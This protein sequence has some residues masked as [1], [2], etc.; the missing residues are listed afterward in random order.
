LKCLLVDFDEQVLI[1]SI[2]NSQHLIIVAEF[3]S[4]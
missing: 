4:E 2:I 3:F 1:V